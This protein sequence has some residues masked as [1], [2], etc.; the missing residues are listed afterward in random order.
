[1]VDQFWTKFEFRPGHAGGDLRERGLSLQGQNIHDAKNWIVGAE[2]RILHIKQALAESLYE[3]A[4]L[5]SNLGSAAAVCNGSRRK[6]EEARP[7]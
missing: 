2:K 7:K 4:A 5:Q 1:M 3:L 6:S